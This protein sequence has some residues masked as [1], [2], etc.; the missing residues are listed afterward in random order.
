MR[1]GFLKK[2][3]DTYYFKGKPIN[4]E[5]IELFDLACFEEW[6]M[7]LT[8][9]PV[10]KWFVKLQRDFKKLV[11][12]KDA[13]VSRPMDNGRV[14]LSLREVADFAV[15]AA[16]FSEALMPDNEVDVQMNEFTELYDSTN[17]PPKPGGPLRPLKYV[18][19]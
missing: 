12:A 17:L 13:L 5:D 6:P 7:P 10:E 3:G 4:R 8:V 18:V 1:T 9:N 16:E 19:L 11:A 15:L 2:R 14:V